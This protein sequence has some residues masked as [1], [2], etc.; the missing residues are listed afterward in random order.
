LLF[1]GGSC[2]DP[3]YAEQPIREEALLN[4]ALDSTNAWHFLA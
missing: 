1:L 2:I 4:G 3:K